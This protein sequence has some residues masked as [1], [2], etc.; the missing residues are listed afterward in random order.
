M[1]FLLEAFFY[2]RTKNIH[3]IINTHTIV[4]KG[5]NF[6]IFLNKLMQAK[7]SNGH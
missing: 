5:E 2:Y 6:F 1:Y 7:L 3:T 4:Y